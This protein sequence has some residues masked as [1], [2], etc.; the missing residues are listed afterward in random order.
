MVNFFPAFINENWRTAWNAQ[1]D[2]RAQA[3][4]IAAK[5]YTSQNLPVPFAASNKVDREFA[6]RIDRAP[7][8]SLIEHFDHIIR[9]AGI[10]HVGIGTDFDGIPATPEG[11]D[12]AAGLPKLTAA[13]MARGHT[14]EDL[15]KLLGGNLLR[16]FREVQGR[17]PSFFRKSNHEAINQRHLDR[18]RAASSRGAAERPLYFS[19]G[20]DQAGL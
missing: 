19:D 12:S 18:S 2:D 3:Q 8:D 13:L 15:H 20:A 14:S 6:A 17:R 16:V 11:I 9:V 1:R 7:F 5:P 4:A 10:D